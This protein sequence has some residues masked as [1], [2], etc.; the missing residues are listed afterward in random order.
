[1]AEASR[2]KSVPVVVRTSQPRPTVTA[3]R[4]GAS[5]VSETLPPLDRLTAMVGSPFPRLRTARRYSYHL[6]RGEG[7][8]RF[9]VALLSLPGIADGWGASATVRPP[10][11]SILMCLKIVSLVQRAVQSSASS[12][13]GA[14][15]GSGSVVI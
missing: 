6:E 9:Q 7:Y 4:P 14:A 5:L 11:C 10:R 12:R 2:S 3:V 15:A 1:M 13:A 8:A